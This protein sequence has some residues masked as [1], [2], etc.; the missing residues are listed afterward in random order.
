MKVKHGLKDKIRKEYRYC[1]SCSR[2]RKD[3]KWR[4]D[5]EQ[6]ECQECYNWWLE[7]IGV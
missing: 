5:T 2:I 4:N 7:S 6:Y 3:V 1:E